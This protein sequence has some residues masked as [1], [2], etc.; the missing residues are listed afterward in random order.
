MNDLK[1]LPEVQQAG[2]Y[3]KLCESILRTYMLS[4][5][6]P[7]VDT[8]RDIYTSILKTTNATIRKNKKGLRVSVGDYCETVPLNTDNSLYLDSISRTINIMDDGTAEGNRRIKSI[9]GIVNAMSLRMS[10][11]AGARKGQAYETMGI[12]SR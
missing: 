2:I 7:S 3:K 8:W 4:Q 6:E 9:H 1:S 5:E 10:S 11:R 12:S